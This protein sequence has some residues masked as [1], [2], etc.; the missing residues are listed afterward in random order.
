MEYWLKTPR[1]KSAILLSASTAHLILAGYPQALHAT[2]LYIIVSMVIIPFNR[3][4]RK[5]AKSDIKKLILWG[6]TAVLICVGL[7][8]I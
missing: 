4:A 6:A 8:A 7:T 2:M 3:Y 1:L 5:K